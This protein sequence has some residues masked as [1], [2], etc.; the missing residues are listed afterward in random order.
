MVAIRVTAFH[1]MKRLRSRQQ[2]NPGVLDVLDVWDL[3]FRFGYAA[4]QLF[5]GWI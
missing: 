4:R 1:F 2:G 5:F 3:G